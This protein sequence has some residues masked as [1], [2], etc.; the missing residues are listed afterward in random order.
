MP[1]PNGEYEHVSSCFLV[2]PREKPSGPFRWWSRRSCFVNCSWSTESTES[3]VSFSWATCS[4]RSPSTGILEDFHAYADLVCLQPITF[5]AS[6][7]VVTFKSPFNGQF[8]FCNV[9]C[10]AGPL[11]MLATFWQCC[12]ASPWH[13]GWMPQEQWLLGEIKRTRN[14][15]EQ[16]LLILPIWCINIFYHVHS[17]S[18]I[19]STV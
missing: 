15:C 8:Q 9:P 13:L 7:L 11:R 17:F 1:Q 19:Y 4:K 6:I 12:L 16:N 10:R 18:I 14:Y 2:K 5:R 3:T